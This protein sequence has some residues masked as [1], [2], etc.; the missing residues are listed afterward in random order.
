MNAPTLYGLTVCLSCFVFSL[1]AQDKGQS[2]SGKITPADFVLP[3]SPAI[4]SNTNAVIL[5]DVGSTHFKGN[6]SGWFSYVF[7]RQVRIKILN[8][9]GLGLATIRIFLHIKDDDKEKLEDLTASTYNLENGAVTESRLVKGDIFEDKPDQHTLEE[10]FTMPGVVNGS[11]IQYSYTITSDF[12]YNLP[13]WEFQSLEAPCLWSEYNVVIP[14]TLRFVFVKRGF[15]PFFLDKQKEGTESYRVEERTDDPLARA[16]HAF[17]VSTNTSIHRWVMKDVPRLPVEDYVTTPLNYSDKL[18]FQLSQTYNGETT[19]DYMNSWAQAT[20]DL[21]KEKTFG[22]PLKEDNDWLDPLLDR[23]APVSDDPLQ[24]AKKIY[25]YLSGNF[26]CTD[27]DS[28]YLKTTLEDV[29]K[30]RNG[31]VGE[32]NLL[33]IALLRRR[34]FKADPVLLSTREFGFNL[35]KYPILERLNY[36]ICR[37][38]IGGNVFFLDASR[39]GLAFGCLPENCYNGHARVISEQD[40]VSVY[41]WADSLRQKEDVLVMLSNS[42]QGVLQGNFQSVSGYPGSYRIRE[43]ARKSGLT[44]F[45]KD[46]QASYGKDLLISNGGIDSLDDPE[47]PVKV[48]YDFECKM[49]KNADLI[50]FD[51]VLKDDFRRNPFSATVRK[52]PVEMAHTLDES[53]V[54]NMEIPVGYSVEEMPKS[55]RV[56][57]NENE[58]SFE[59]MIE[60][61]GNLILMRSRIRLDR[62]EFLPEDYNMLRDFFAYI[63]KK[64]NEQIV[65]KKKP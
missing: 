10:K 13:D 5:S 44:G 36:V 6:Q 20:A 37:A 33:L 63:A 30:R 59:Y 4:D 54:L 56:S 60:R 24:Q 41:F 42:D 15:H 25:Y 62:T 57:F 47:A 51:P 27:H 35:A 16:D 34:H 1:S 19:R 23:I 58:G 21:L 48:H 38:G 28:K 53:Y 52:Y 26:T 17:E 12:Y 22:E 61:Q 64:Q 65:F 14:N 11:I 29:V 50:Y 7:K 49:D 18:E 32:L 9:Q 39:P 45:F 8:K 43:K 46:L 3:S 2:A 55:A 31:S 40:S